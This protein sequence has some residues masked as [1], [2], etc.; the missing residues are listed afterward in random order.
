MRRAVRTGSSWGIAPLIGNTYRNSPA[1]ASARRGCV[2][3][4]GRCE[5]RER[6]LERRQET[7]L[8]TWQR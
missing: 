6:L 5:G 1:D 2:S 3:C 4:G 8:T 7:L